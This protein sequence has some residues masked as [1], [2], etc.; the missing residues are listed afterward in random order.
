[1]YGMLVEEKRKGN[2]LQLVQAE[3]PRWCWCHM[4]MSSS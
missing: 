1:V 2:V 4:D 3:S